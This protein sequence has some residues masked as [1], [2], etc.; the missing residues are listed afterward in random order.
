MIRL[1]F[2][3]IEPAA[4]LWDAGI[5]ETLL[6]A[7]AATTAV[8]AVVGAAGQAQA[9][10]QAAQAY[11]QQQAI[12]QENAQIA[13]AQAQGQAAIDRQQTL[14]AEGRVAAAYGTAGMTVGEGSP[15]DVMRAQAAQGELTRE[16]DLYKGTV[17]ATSAEQQ[18]QIYGL[19][20]QSALTGGQYAA[21]GTLLTGFGAA[22]R[23]GAQLFPAPSGGAA[24]GP[25]FGIPAPPP[26]VS[27]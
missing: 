11:T 26:I 1:Y 9:G 22:A 2:A 5:G 13:M 20:S 10:Q 19:E 6:A 18:A 25:P 24:A 27:Y 3:P 23:Y 15:L 17:A 21:G 14:I 8:G 16:L 7:S 12:A 4:L